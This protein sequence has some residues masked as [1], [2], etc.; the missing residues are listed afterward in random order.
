MKNLNISAVILAI[1][2]ASSTNAMAESITKQHHNSVTN[3]INAEYRVAKNKC[4]L[5][6][7]IA[8]ASC[9]AQ[10]RTAK[11]KAI[12]NTTSEVKTSKD[13]ASINNKSSN[14]KTRDTS[15]NAINEDYDEDEMESAVTEVKPI[16]SDI[17]PLGKDIFKDRIKIVAMR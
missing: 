16:E 14:N 10:A 12:A 7:I 17:T 11:T 5:L 6:S 1:S 13:C 8:E 4:S 2:F 15:A 3:S 9:I